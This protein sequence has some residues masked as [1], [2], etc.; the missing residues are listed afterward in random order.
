MA[1]EPGRPA[2]AGVD[3]IDSLLGDQPR[4]PPDRARRLKGV[5]AGDRQ[6]RVARA[7]LRSLLPVRLAFARDD[8]TP[9]GGNQGT[10]YVERAAFHA[11][12]AREAR[13]HL[14]DR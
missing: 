4:E 2:R 13:Q 10:R 6:R 14:K 5:A 1:G 12:P 3:E 8:G 9:A 11:A 7:G